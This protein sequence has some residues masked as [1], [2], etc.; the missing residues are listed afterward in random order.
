MSE[1]KVNKISPRTNCGT[2]TVGDSGDSVSVTAGVPVTVNGDLKSNALKAVDGGSIISQCGT[3]IT[4]GASGDTINLAAGASQTGF[5]RTGTVDWDTT[6][7]TAS[8]TAVSGNGYFVNTTSGAITLTLPASPSAGDI[9]SVKDY[10]Y[11]FETNNLTVNRNGSPIGGGSDTDTIS[12]STN[13]DFLTFIYV[14]ATQ[15]WVLTNDSTNTDSTGAEYITAT[16]GTI[17][18]VGDF[19]VHQFTGPGTFT[20]T[21]T[22]NP[23]G[24]TQVDYL[25]VGGGGSGGLYPGTGG[26]GAGG[27][28]IG[29]VVDTSPTIPIRAPGFTVSATSYPI[30][31][32]AGGTPTNYP[33]NNPTR[34]PNG[35]PSSALGFTATGGGGGAIAGAS[36]VP[37]EGAQTGGSGGGGGFNGQA[38]AAG[39][40]P[41]VSPP[42]GNNGG[43]GHPTT[44]NPSGGGGGGGAGAV[45]SN[46]SG[47]PV[48]GGAGG[49]GINVSPVFGTAPQPF[50]IANQSGNAG[51]TACGQFAGGAGG[52]SY[53][54]S[55]SVGA[56]GG[57]A[58][59][60]VNSEGNGK[61]GTTNSG[62]G[63]AGTQ[64]LPSNSGAGGSG[65]VLIRY[66]FQN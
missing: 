41:P 3:N 24:S 42:Q 44:C 28:R 49:A 19:K 55:P 8:F 17:T 52:S 54:G 13:G 62:G 53:S 22:G 20:V 66:K 26:G 6:A 4:L 40:T 61:N 27:M 23:G 60:A 64:S 56:I 10:A 47:G 16:G 32:G 12:Y 30:T 46:G 21:C 51:N 36:P 15:G 25:V 38:G 57:G 11:T 31:I 33:A 45:G 34:A 5:G 63:G 65:I 48:G 1:V 43:T 37:Q 50:Y 14:D 9:V 39:N 58:N 18:T 35:S 29:S 59:G 2:V 7:K